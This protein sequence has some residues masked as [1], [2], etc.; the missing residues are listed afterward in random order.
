[1]LVITIAG[2]ALLGLCLRWLGVPGEIAAVVNN[3][4]LRE[5][6]LPTRQSP[7]M[8]VASLVSIVAGGSAGPEAPLVQISG[9]LG[10]WL[11][12]R[13]RWF[14][15]HVRTLTFC[16][17][18]A[19]LGA[20]FG[21]PLAGA[22]FALEIPHRNGLEY[23]EALLPALVAAF[24]S[25]WIFDAFS[26]HPHPLFLME[27]PLPPLDSG[28]VGKG[29]L[30][31]AIGAALAL[32]FN[33][34]FNAV[35]QAFQ[36]WEKWHVRL[37]AAGGLLIGLIALASPDQLPVSTLFWG[38]FQ[39]RELLLLVQEGDLARSLAIPLLALCALKMLAVSVTLTTG[40]RGGFI[41]PLFFIGGTAGIALSGFTNGWF[42][43]PVAVLC[44]MAAT[45][46]GV[47]RTPVSSTVLLATL[48]GMAAVPLL[49]AAS[50]T[51]FLLTARVRMIA[52]QR[53]RVL[54]GSLTWR[55]QE[56]R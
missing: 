33:R 28:L 14:S 56:I 12:D 17:M 13:L 30:L 47:T 8:F 42:P 16:G 22:I 35:R 36:R 54:P 49:L 48:S 38:E 40:F 24:F 15:V 39:M 7:S 53:S 26:G 41:F 25:F 20:F 32:G 1:L 23:Y 9:S 3:I 5:G 11:G 31:G 21:A 19:A 6:R 34:L 10:S 50:L 43:L 18:A 44:L 2:G 27:M 52:T 55:D 46:V 45:N 29:V 51:S 37:G 4:H